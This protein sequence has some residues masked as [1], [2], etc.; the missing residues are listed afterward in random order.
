MCIMLTPKVDH[1]FVIGRCPMAVLG[2][3]G[4]TNR[5]KDMTKTRPKM[6]LWLGDGRGRYIPRDFAYSFAARAES[7]SGVDDETWAILEAG[8]DHEHYWDAWADVEND[9]VITDEHGTK[10][11]IYNND[12]CWLVP[13]GMKWSDDDDSFVWPDGVGRT[14]TGVKDMAMLLT[15]LAPEEHAYPHGRR[16]RRCKAICPDGK[17][18]V[19]WAGIPDTYFTIPAHTRIKGKYAR[20]YLSL[21]DDGELIMN[22]Y[23]S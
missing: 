11:H 23:G 21:R 10:Y 18:R 4:T 20:G 17:I 14:Q 15:Y 12:D 19:V 9:A 13:D 8:P 2:L 5:D 1:A 22:I 3:S 7:V 6:I 16:T